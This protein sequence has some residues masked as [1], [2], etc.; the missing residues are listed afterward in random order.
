[1]KSDFVSSDGPWYG[2]KCVF[3]HHDVPK[4]GVGQV[5]EERIVLVQASSPA[6]AIELGE[7]EA[8]EYARANHAEYLGFIDAFHMFAAEVGPGTEVYSLMRTSHLT[9][10]DFVSWYYDDGTQHSR[11]PDEG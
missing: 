10:E 6:Q 2:A 3:L 1:M 5:F 8:R 4:Q 11:P 7:A 9:P